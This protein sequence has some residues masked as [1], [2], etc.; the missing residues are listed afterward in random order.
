MEGVP[1]LTPSPCTDAKTSL[2]RSEREGRL[3]E[4]N[5]TTADEP[6]SPRSLQADRL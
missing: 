1:T 5:G 4:T 3:I 6:I 2:T